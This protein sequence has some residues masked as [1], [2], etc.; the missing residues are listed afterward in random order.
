[1][2]FDLPIKIILVFGLLILSAFF[3]GS[4][5]AFFSLKQ[6]KI[7]DAFR[8]SKLILRYANNLI[9]APRRLLVVI[10]IGNTI[11]NVAAS[12]VAVAIALEIAAQNSISINLILTIQIV[13]LT[14]IILLFSELVPKLF[15]SK[16]P[17]LVMKITAI[18]LYLFSIVI[19][20]IAE[21]L[22]ELIRFTTARITLDKSKTAITEKELADLAEISHERGTIEEE[23]QEIITSFVE[24]KS[25]LV[26][27]VMTPRV[28]MTAVADNL[29]FDKL[30]ETIT[31]SGHSR[32]PVYKENLD[33]IIGIIYAKDLLSYLGDEDSVVNESPANLVR[34]V[35]FVPERKKI[36]E[37]LH[38][39]QEKKT[40]IAIVVDE[41]GGTAGLVTLEDIIEEVVGEIWDEYDEEED[42]IQII[43]PNKFLVLGKVSVEDF[44]TKVGYEIIPNSEEYDTIGGLIFHQAGSIPKEGFSIEIE[45][46]K[47][48]VKEVLKK[49]I[50][51]VEIEKT[52]E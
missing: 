24:F 14:L 49:R 36:N 13:L 18:P 41:Y 2:E 40:H 31:K 52:S 20:P 1:M 51:R 25:V 43:S 47:L 10:L 45:N 37:M 34:Q 32:I 28:D 50:K 21:S 26:S 4:E 7:E 15:A 22:T 44:N 19:Y 33:T 16:H 9:N 17:L 27:E 38:E 48:S 23:E 3:S 12:I 30:I 39:F 42:A 29:T 46:L 6:K 8:D 35:I 11:T 5:V